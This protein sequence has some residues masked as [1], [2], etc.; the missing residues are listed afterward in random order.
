MI[1]VTLPKGTV[2]VKGETVHCLP[3]QAGTAG[4]EFV[5]GVKFTEVGEDDRAGWPSS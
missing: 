3:H 4:R 1:I 2:A 5:V